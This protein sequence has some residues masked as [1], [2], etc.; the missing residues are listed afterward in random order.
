MIG[1][2]WFDPFHNYLAIEFTTRAAT[3]KMPYLC[4]AMG[5]KMTKLDPG[6][7]AIAEICLNQWRLPE[8]WT[9]ELPRGIAWYPDRLRYELV[10][11][12]MF[13]DLGTQLSRVTSRVALVDNIRLDLKTARL[14]LAMMNRLALGSAL[15]LDPDKRTVWSLSSM[16]IHEETLAWRPSFY[17]GLAYIQVAQAV[18]TA[19]HLAEAL[20]GN[21]AIREHP[22]SGLRPDKDE[23]LIN[24]DRLASA[25]PKAGAFASAQEFE[26]LEEICA[27][28]GLTTF[29]SSHEG[30]AAEM[31]FGG[32]TILFQLLV[33]QP[34]PGF[35]TGL[36]VL[37]QVPLN[38][39]ADVAL[40]CAASLNHYEAT[41]GIKSHL[42]GAWTVNER[43][44]GQFVV[45]YNGFRPDI[46]YRPGIIRDELMALV[47]RARFLRESLTGRKDSPVEPWGMILRRMGQLH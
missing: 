29:G 46:L 43:S 40:D 32:D 19:E 5:P 31:E 24:F 4:S 27:K 15:H 33:N 13:E 45:A 1:A 11:S 22:V 6:L 12:P 9:E 26:E 37:L 41:E 14:Q 17:S 2:Y 38:S 35:G 47:M 23:F 28:I 16:L 10:A 44:K 36:L 30:I 25:G 8:K 3:R 42:Q 7:A 34:H 21:V 39:D 18:R 20:Q